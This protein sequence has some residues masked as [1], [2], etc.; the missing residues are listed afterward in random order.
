MAN[1]NKK[2]TR[3]R[4]PAQSK[5]QKAKEQAL[6]AEKREAVNRIRRRS[7]VCGFNYIFLRSRCQR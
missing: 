6:K 7:S 3:K 4:K 1:N 5:N 2:N